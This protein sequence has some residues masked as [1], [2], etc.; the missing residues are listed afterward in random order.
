MTCRILMKFVMRVP[1]KIFPN[2]Y[3]FCAIQH[4]IDYLLSTHSTLT[5]RFGQTSLKE[6]HI[7]LLNICVFCEN[8]WSE[9]YN[10]LMAGNET[11]LTV[12]PWNCT[13][14]W[15]QIVWAGSRMTTFLLRDK[16][17]HLDTVQ[18]LFSTNKWKQ[19]IRRSLM[20]IRNQGDFSVWV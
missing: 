7:I 20:S 9:V 6:G 12:V 18:Y 10:F 3:K 19:E 17:M 11:P 4:G 16:F 1:H 2:H 13:I 8:W 14:F 15:E 5:V